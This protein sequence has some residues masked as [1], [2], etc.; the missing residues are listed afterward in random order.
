MIKNKY[1]DKALL[2]S[3]TDLDGSGAVVIAKALFPTIDCI[4]P[5][6]EDLDCSIKDSIMSGKYKLIIMTD[7]SPKSEEVIE[8][9]NKYSL[10]GNEFILLDHH[11]TAL[12]LNKYNW[13]FVKVETDG[14]KHSG[15][16]L[17]YNHLKNEG[18]DVSM[19][20]EFTELIRSY[21]TWDWFKN[22]F[23][24]PEKLNRLFYFLGLEKFTESMHYKIENNLPLFNGEDELSL[25]A[26]DI[27]NKQY[28]EKNKNKFEVIYYEG[29][30]VAVIF[31]DNCISELG[32]TICYENADIDFC[33]LIDLNS[34]KCAL[35][36]REGRVDVSVIAK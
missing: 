27:V 29:K 5:N 2:I 14:K 12:G 19:F 9:I 11:K 17:F 4:T 24:T 34:K 1:N 13:S 31:T 10:E 7:C 22:N 30:K 3:D 23:K 28:I 33:C 25:R 35:R 20:E 18:I 6:R 16:E 21:D 15:T 36:S 26:I 32:N 8:L